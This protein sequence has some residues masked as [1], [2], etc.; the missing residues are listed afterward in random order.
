MADYNV[1]FSH[2]TLERPKIFDTHVVT[3]TMIGVPDNLNEQA[4]R[5]YITAELM[6]TVE[7]IAHIE[8]LKISAA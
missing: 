4:L 7:G 5:A 3:R 8:G 6:R 2:S 1:E